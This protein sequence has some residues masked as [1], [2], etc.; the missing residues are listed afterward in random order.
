MIPNL[1]SSTS[2]TLQQLILLLAPTGVGAHT[3][4]GDIATMILGT[5]GHGVGIAL[6]TTA[7]GMIGVGMVI[8]ITHGPIG[9]VLGAATGVATGLATGV[10]LIAGI[11]DGMDITTTVGT[12]DV[13]LA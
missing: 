7:V 12:T 13:V 3:G 5:A 4:D 11:M 9:D 6:G 1:L 8:A 10:V 2:I